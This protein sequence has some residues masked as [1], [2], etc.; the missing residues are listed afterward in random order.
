MPATLNIDDSRIPSDE[1][2]QNYTNGLDFSTTLF[3]IDRIPNPDISGS[4]KSESDF[5][6]YGAPFR[7]DNSLTTVLTGV[8][9]SS[10]SILWSCSICKQTTTKENKQQHL[11]ECRERNLKCECGRTFVSKDKLAQHILSHH[12]SHQAIE[13]EHKSNSTVF[14]CDK[15]QRSYMVLLGVDGADGAARAALPLRRLSQGVSHSE[16]TRPARSDT[17]PW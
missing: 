15:C 8:E 2:F 1:S 7:D 11:R 17:P 6:T 5:N 14:K 4:S 13:K 9:G 3:D 16:Q 12:T 10:E